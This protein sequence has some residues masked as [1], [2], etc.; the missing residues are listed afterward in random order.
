MRAQVRNDLYNKIQD[1]I[2]R[3]NK[4]YTNQKYVAHEIDFSEQ[5][6]PPVPMMRMAIVAGNAAEA[7]P[8]APPLTVANKLIM[9]ANVTL[10][11]V[12]RP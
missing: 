7:A 9:T 8:S 5:S 11:E 4:I 1:E 2:I 6:A 3:I 10:A 12:V